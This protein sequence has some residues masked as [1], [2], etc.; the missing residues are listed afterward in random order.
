MEKV[1]D[2]VKKYKVIKADN[3]EVGPNGVVDYTPPFKLPKGTRAACHLHGDKPVFF[4]TLK[5]IIKH[6]AVMHDL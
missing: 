5:D 3:L 4:K 2:V 6:E 1:G